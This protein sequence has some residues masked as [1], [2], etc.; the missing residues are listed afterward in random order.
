MSNYIIGTS[1]F[2]TI[3]D[4]CS[5][6]M[7]HSKMTAIIG[8]PGAGKT[9]ALEWFTSEHEFVYYLK[10][11]PS[12]SARQFYTKILNVM[13]IEGKHLGNTLHDLINDIAFRLNYNPIKK[14]LIV[15]E[16]GKFKMK[17]L[18]Y[19]HEIRDKT[20]KSTGIVL[21]GP[22]YFHEN[23]KKWKNKG[24]IGVPE[25]YRRINHWEYLSPPTITETRKLCE[26]IGLTDEH[27]IKEIH[28]TS[29]NFSEITYKAENELINQ[30][31]M[32]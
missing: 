20:D 6:T 30:K 32:K 21:A 16:A 2:N 24:I 11:E 29:E 25:L 14:L 9:T 22:E 8:Y 12:M 31:K 3:K 28:N 26:M 5:D 7:N 17:F 15:D 13:G 19:L 27:V 1:N 10:V 18:E 4:L 23:L